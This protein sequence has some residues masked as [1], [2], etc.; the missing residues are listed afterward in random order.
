MK[1]KNKKRFNKKN[2]KKENLFNYIC[3]QNKKRFEFENI[4]Y[5]N[6]HGYDS[7]TAIYEL[8]NYLYNTLLLQKKQK[9]YI[10]HG[11]GKF[12]LAT[13]IKKFLDNCKFIKKSEY[14][15]VNEGGAGVTIAE[16]DNG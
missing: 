5:I 6:L 16:I 10:N 11:K 12:I 9:V 14:A 7:E 13:S 15:G 3:N 1:Q 8:E 2:K 4:G